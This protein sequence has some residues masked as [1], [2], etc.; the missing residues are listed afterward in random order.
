MSLTQELRVYVDVS[1]GD[2]KRLPYKQ[3]SLT[4]MSDIGYG[5]GWKVRCFLYDERRNAQSSEAKIWVFK[6]FCDAYNK[7][8]NLL[9]TL[10]K[11]TTSVAITEMGVNI[12]VYRFNSAN[13]LEQLQC[14][15]YALHNRIEPVA[16]KNRSRPRSHR[17]RKTKK[18][19]K[20]DKA[21]S[22]GWFID[23]KL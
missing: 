1:S 10:V 14:Y 8:R 15:M 5:P 18:S 6:R 7:T 16:A 17:G 13:A 9:S 4:P 2:H 23:T 3:V 20:S 12:E 22:V 19:R 21:K 11:R